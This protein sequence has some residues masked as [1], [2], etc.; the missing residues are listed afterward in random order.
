MESIQAQERYAIIGTC[1]L[2]GA[3]NKADDESPSSSAKKID[4]AK[5]HTG[6]SECS[7]EDPRLG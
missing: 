7:L 2:K 5:V 3:Y 4:Q 6:A 1:S